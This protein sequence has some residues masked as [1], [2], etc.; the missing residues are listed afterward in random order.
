MSNCWVSSRT[1][2]GPFVQ[3]R[4]KAASYNASSSRTWIMARAR[5]PSLPG[6]TRSQQ[7]ALSTTL[8]L[9][10]SMTMSLAPRA[11]ARLIRM[12]SVGCEA[13]GL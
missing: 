6:R 5:A 10:G 8:A 2:K 13:W 9:C 4:T 12:A 7:S 1:R 3:A 11:F